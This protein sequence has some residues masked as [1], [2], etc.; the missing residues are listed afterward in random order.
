MYQ[1]KAKSTTLLCGSKSTMKI[2]KA[3]TTTNKIIN[4]TEKIMRI[5]IDPMSILVMIRELT[6]TV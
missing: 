6:A 1:N 3:L 2:S 4:N 5:E